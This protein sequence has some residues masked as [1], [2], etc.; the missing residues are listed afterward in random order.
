MLGSVGDWVDTII[1]AF[2]LLVTDFL[3]AGAFGLVFGCDGCLVLEC[4]VIFGAEVARGDGLG[5]SVGLGFSFD[6]VEDGLLVEGEAE[7]NNASFTTV[8]INKT[9]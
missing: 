9:D 8:L 6:L 7:K 3:T 4:L 1:S 2:F 5:F